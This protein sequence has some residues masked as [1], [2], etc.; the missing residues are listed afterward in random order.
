MS[1]DG[2]G[3]VYRVGFIAFE[4]DVRDFDNLGVLVILNDVTQL[5]EGHLLVAVFD[6]H[7]CGAGRCWSSRHGLLKLW[8]ETSSDLL[9]KT[10]LSILIFERL[11]LTVTISV[12]IVVKNSHFAFLSSYLF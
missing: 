2:L 4:L 6:G 11:T 9:A 1:T 5:L 7:A 10:R 3:E 12:R 8:E